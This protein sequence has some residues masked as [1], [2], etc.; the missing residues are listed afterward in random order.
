MC[1]SLHKKGMMHM[2]HISTFNNTRSGTGFFVYVIFIIAGVILGSLLAAK[3]H[4]A[5]SVWI[6]QGFMPVTGCSVYAV[7]RNT[8]LS[9]TFFV[10]AA[11]MLGLSAVGQPFGLAL[12]IY[13]GIGI[14]VAVTTLYAL[15]GTGTV[16]RVLVL[17]FPKALAV[18]AISVLAVRET[19]RSSNSLLSYLAKRNE[20]DDNRNSIRLYGLKF[21]V[22]ILLSLLISA[23]DGG[24]N[25]LYSAVSRH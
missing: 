2:K 4:G 5:V 7:I 9:L 22:L 11:F 19:V 13:R 14:G 3:H 20:R 10:S 17:V 25:Y 18:S 12:L 6:E 21:V 16:M 15:F 24:V 1:I 8:F 23:A